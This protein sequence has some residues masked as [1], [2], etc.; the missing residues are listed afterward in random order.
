MQAIGIEQEGRIRA[1]NP[2]FIS[3][4]ATPQNRS[5]AWNVWLCSVFDVLAPDCDIWRD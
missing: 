1:K 3:S 4:D 5:H 2:I